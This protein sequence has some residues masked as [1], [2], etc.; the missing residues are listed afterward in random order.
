MRTL[1]LF[2][3]FGLFHTICFTQADSDII[4]KRNIYNKKGDYYFNRKEFKKAIL[5]YGMAFKNDKSDYFSILKKA[6]AYNKLKLYPQ[7]EACYRI[8]FESN[9]RAENIYKLK[10]ALVLF[11]NNKPEEF[12]KWISDYNQFIEDEIESDNYL[13]SSEKR[14]QLYKDTAIVLHND[15][16]TIDSIKFKI[17]YGGYQ[18]RRR[19]AP[20]DNMLNLVVSSGEEYYIPASSSGSFDFSFQP[21]E[22]YKLIIQREDISAEG[23]LQSDTLTPIQKQNRFLNPPPV[24]KSEIIIPHGM[25]YQFSIGNE[26]IDSEYLTDLEDMAKNYQK[27]D[28]DAINLTALAK[29]LQLTGGEIY[30]IRFI[31][32][33]HQDETY[34]KFEISNLF[35]NN[36]S[37]NIFGQSFLVVMPLKTESNFNIVTD[38]EDLEKN[39]NPKKYSLSIDNSPVF[40]EEHISDSFIALNVNTK[41]PEEVLPAHRISGR[42]ISIIPGAVYILT[43]SKP[44]PTRPGREI[45][46]IVPL[47]QGI[48][49]NLGASQDSDIEY[50]EALAEFLMGRE[51]LEL[52]N[53]EIIDISI[54]SKELEVQPGED[55]SF[56]LLPAR[57]YGEETE[58]PKQILS[59]L[60]VDG[61]EY[62]IS[63][64]E[65]YTINIPFGTNR[66]VNLQTALDYV[67]ENFDANSYTVLLDTV[68]FTSEIV[69]DTTGYGALK[70]TGWL[71]MSVNTES[72]AEVEKQFQ[73]IANEV[74]IIPGKEYILTVSKLDAETGKEEEIIVPLI[75]KV[76]YDFTANPVS[77]EEYKVSLAKF[78]EERKDLETTD[79]TLIDIKLLSKELQIEEGDKVSFSLLPAKVFNKIP[80]VEPMVKSSLFLDNKVVEF[81]QIQKYTINMPL[82][83]EQQ[84]NMQTNL[85]HLQENFE[86]GTYTVEVDT[87]SFFSE[88]TIDTAGLGDRIVHDEEITDPVFDVVVINFD[89][90]EHVLK[91]DAKNTIKKS[92]IDELKS[93][94]RLYVTIKGYT[95]PLGDTD[96]NFRLSRRRAESVKTFLESNGIGEKRIRTFSF[97]ESETLEAGV[98]W[99]DLDEAELKKYRRVEIVIYLPE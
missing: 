81:T 23:I 45:E 32:D 15:N 83:K 94:S 19:T 74:S 2:I 86:P 85:E 42:K 39:F 82:T 88:I 28:E 60:I 55:L 52:A 29:E 48:K 12:R 92:V 20:E 30:T 11:N 49:Y 72:L 9:K 84:V 71:S 34:K 59:N 6:E 77:E 51:G 16:Q 43:L 54:L 24:Q 64:G 57:T 91:P 67:T 13:I 31:R 63:P 76:K 25:K 4:E 27:P 21:L 78:L 93:D 36:R 50:K 90:N 73:F 7:A 8:V 61:V 58:T 95:D 40:K 14:L 66:K 80:S 26:A 5:F 97:G 17:K 37:V 10:Y 35:I 79:G 47:T 69:V 75:R 99:E 46:V 1:L 33:E 62:E 22:N 18:P 3:L 89:L 96:Y 38:I 68:S 65:K 41:A 56:H 87:S 98:N 70:S 53:E 44:H